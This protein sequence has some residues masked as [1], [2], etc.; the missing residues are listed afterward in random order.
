MDS[1]ILV[2]DDSAAIQK[3]RAPGANGGVGT[4]LQSRFRP[5]GL[6]IPAPV[7]RGN[8]RT[9]GANCA[10][11]IVTSSHWNPETPL[12]KASVVPIENPLFPIRGSSQTCELEV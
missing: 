12:V 9:M 2:V 5:P 7:F 8:F 3:H 6:T 4:G 1:E 11:C 10:D